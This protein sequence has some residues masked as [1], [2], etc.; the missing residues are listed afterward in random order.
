MFFDRMRYELRLMGKRVILTP[1]LVMVGFAL[2]A[3]L[4]HYLHTDPA[5]FLSGGLEIILPLA[6]G[7]VI[8]TITSHDPVIEVQLTVPKLYHLTVLLRLFLIVIWTACIALLS[9]SALSALKLVYMLQP[10]SPWSTPLQFLLRQ[11][12]W[13]APLFWFA[14][15]GLCLALLTRSRSASGALLCGIWLIEI[16]FKDFI[17][18]TTWL[19]PVSLFPTTLVFPSTSVPQLYFNFWL[20]SRF[21]VLVMALVLLPVGWLLLHNPEGLLKGSSEE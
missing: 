7:V 11:L 20:T 16:I 17:F 15:V 3:E 12:V 21:E 9:S 5:R 2:F 19:R 1:I 18:S 6:A 8:A 10:A 4:L 13:S 14:T